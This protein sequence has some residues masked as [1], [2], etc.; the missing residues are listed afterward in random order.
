MH[1]DADVPA[2]RHAASHPT[3]V[4]PSVVMTLHL[5]GPSVYVPCVCMSPHLRL[6]VAPLCIFLWIIVP[7]RIGSLCVYFSYCLSLH[8]RF[9]SSFDRTIEPNCLEE[10]ELN[11]EFLIHLNKLGTS[12]KVVSQAPR[13]ETPRKSWV[14]GT[15]RLARRSL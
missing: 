2:P 11:N 1:W 3:T 6:Y 10:K 5:H 12:R 15:L 13:H 7:S 4:C 9:Y 8:V 14:Q